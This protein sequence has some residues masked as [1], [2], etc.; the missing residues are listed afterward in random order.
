MIDFSATHSRKELTPIEVT[1]EGSE[2]SVN[3]EQ[4][5]NKEELIEVICAEITALV[6][7][8][9]PSKQKSSIT[10]TDEGIVTF[11]SE[12]HRLNALY[13]IVVTDEGMSIVLSEVHLANEN[14]LS[15]VIDEG[16]STSSN[17]EHFVKTPLPIAVTEEG[18]DTFFNDE[19]P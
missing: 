17:D 2:T 7:F 15:S 14:P 5:L 3:D 11:S 18:I 16:R 12:E 6:S 19:H 1:E 8:L 13:F 9:Q 4:S 10:F